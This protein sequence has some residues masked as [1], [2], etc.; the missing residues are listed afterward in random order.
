VQL[1]EPDGRLVSVVGAIERALA[2][3]MAGLEG[4]EAKRLAQAAARAARAVAAGD[5]GAPIH[6]PSG[7]RYQGAD[8]SERRPPASAVVRDF[9]LE[10][11]VRLLTPPKA[12]TPSPSPHTVRSPGG[13]NIPPSEEEKQEEEDKG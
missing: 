9:G 4:K 5:P 2:P 6:L 13:Y 3:R 11:V 10:E 1:A 12:E 8:G 7:V